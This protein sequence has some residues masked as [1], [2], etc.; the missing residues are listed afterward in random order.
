[1]LVGFKVSYPSR[2]RLVE[3][4]PEVEGLDRDA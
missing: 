3:A 4:D 1:M 2:D